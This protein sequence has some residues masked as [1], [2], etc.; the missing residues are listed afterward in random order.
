VPIFLTCSSF[1]FRCIVSRTSALFAGVRPCLVDVNP[2]KYPVVRWLQDCSALG[3]S[4]LPDCARPRYLR[5]V[6]GALSSIATLPLL[7]NC[8]ANTC[9]Q[10]DSNT[11][12]AKCDIYTRPSIAI[13][14]QLSS[15]SAE[16]VKQKKNKRFLSALHP[17]RDASFSAALLPSKSSRMTSFS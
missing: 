9:G 7:S 13:S 11:G 4:N 16:F 17:Q 6:H 3:K 8:P 14:N 12:H 15:L 5:G 1:H 2:F 10:R